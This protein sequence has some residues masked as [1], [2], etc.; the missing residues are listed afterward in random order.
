[1]DGFCVGF[2]GCCWFLTAIAVVVIFA[3]ITL[4]FVFA[5]ICSGYSGLNVFI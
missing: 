2:L 1:M 4:V 5:A 3:A